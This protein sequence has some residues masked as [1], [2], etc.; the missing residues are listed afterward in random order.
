MKP[1]TNCSVLVT[2]PA[3]Q[4]QNLCA[5]I[6]A[7]GGRAIS[8]PTIE[9]AAAQDQDI[10]HTQVEQLLTH[11]IVIFISPNAVTTAM[12]MVREVWP[13]WPHSV[14]IAAVGQSTAHLLRSNGLI[15]DYYPHKAYNSEELLALPVFREVAG[16]KIMLFRGEGGRELLAKTLIE[17][18]AKVTEVIAY[19][20]K[21]PKIP[22]VLPFEQNEIDIIVS[23]SNTG[24]QNL[25][26]MCRGMDRSWLQNMS[27]LVVSERMIPVMKALGFVKPPVFAENATDPAIVRALVNW[28]EKVNGECAI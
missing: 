28:Q 24:L 7:L 17:R 5:Q 22:S 4:A 3:H 6:C 14:K 10:I 16:K 20:R 19:R 27:L 13:I 23:T 8:F 18:G 9:I 25:F 12:P 21:L 11:E 1:L 2:R 15:A 26:E